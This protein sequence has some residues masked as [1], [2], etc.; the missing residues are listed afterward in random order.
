MGAEQMLPLFPLEVVLLPGAKLPLHIFEE[1]Y[2]L[3]VGEAEKQRS[4]F[5]VILSTQG[6]LAAAGCT[7]TVERITHRYDD[8]RFDIEARG[9]RRFTTISLDESLPC[10]QAR[11]AYFDDEETAPANPKQL[12]RLTKITKQIAGDLGISPAPKIDR[13]T[14]QPSFQIA[15][16]L[17]L[18]LS[19][20]QDLLIKRSEAER[21]GELVRYLTELAERIKKTKQAQRLAATNGHTRLK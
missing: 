8:G 5:G 1:R 20:K 15:S 16:V 6:K 13:S 10:L 7:A 17:P 3:M 12:A 9:R 14:K 2:K 21:L 19:F 4:E 18:E 11:V